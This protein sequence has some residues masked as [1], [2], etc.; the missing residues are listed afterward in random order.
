[1]KT[2]NAMLGIF[3]D[4]FPLVGP[5]FWMLSVQYFMTQ[6]AVALAWSQP[7]SLL[8]NTISDLGN[9]AC[10]PYGDRFVCSPLHAWM[11]ASFVT[12]GISMVAGSMLIYHEF[13][14]SAASVLGF[15]FMGLAGV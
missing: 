10:G 15:S 1:M 4:H 13:H 8:R 5:I 3:N 11:N 6:V 9:T 14:K 12:L 7:Y 2:P